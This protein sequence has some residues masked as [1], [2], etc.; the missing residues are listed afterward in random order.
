MLLIY[1]YWYILFV[2]I[3]YRYES[4]YIIIILRSDLT[5]TNIP[6]KHNS[7]YYKLFQVAKKDDTYPK[8]SFEAK[9]APTD[10][11]AAVADAEKSHEDG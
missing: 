6:C 4:S 11:V 9:E 3:W 10:N 2:S 8:K 7:D 1:I 5:N